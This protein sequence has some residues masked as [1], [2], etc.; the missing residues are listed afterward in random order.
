MDDHPW[1]DSDEADDE[2]DRYEFP[3]NPETHPGAAVYEQIMSGRWP[4]SVPMDLEIAVE[5]TRI[6]V[7]P[8]SA[9]DDSAANRQI[10]TVMIQLDRSKLRQHLLYDIQQARSNNLSIL[11]DLMLLARVDKACFLETAAAHF[12]ET[13]TKNEPTPTVDAA[14]VTW[15]EDLHQWDDTLIARVVDATRRADHAA[16]ERLRDWIL[17]C[18]AQPAVREVLGWLV[19]AA[20]AES[21][22]DR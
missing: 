3:L 15:L 21:V 2:F 14:F 12:V 10:I 6:H 13:L 7:R 16:G 8:P 5:G 17:E 22:E 1:T 19:A 20:I 18:V 9:S 11:P 4:V